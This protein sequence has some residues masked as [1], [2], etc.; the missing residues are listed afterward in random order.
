MTLSRRQFL[1]NAGAAAVAFGGLSSL[2]ALAQVYAVDPLRGTDR[3]GQL[4]RDPDGILNLP[5]GFS[6]RVISRTGDTMSDGLTTPSA[7]DGMAA[8]PAPGKPGYS[9]LVRNHE[10]DSIG[11]EIGPFHHAPARARAMRDRAFDLYQDKL[12]VNGGTTTLLYNHRSG[13]VEKSHLSLLGTTRNCAGGATPWGSWLTCEES[14]A[15]RAEGFGRDHGF[16][17]E[18]PANAEGLVTPEPLT[19]MGR[20]VHEAAAVD[21]S[22]GIVYLTED[23]DNALFYRFLPAQSEQLRHGGQLQ[24][25]AIKGWPGALTRNWEEDKNKAE[26]SAVSV[27]QKFQCTW[28]DL[29]DVASPDGDLSLRG[30][31]AGAARFCRCEGV[32]FALR[33]DGR[34][35]IYFAATGGGPQK[36]GQIWCYRP[37]RHEGAGHEIAGE[38]ELVYESR[39]RA[40]LESCDNLAIAPW[41]DLIICE[42]SYSSSPDMV[43]YIRGLTPEGKLYTLAMNAHPDKGEFCGA[44]FSPDGSTLFVNIQRP[45]MTLAINGPWSR[46]RA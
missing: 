5:Q 35:E 32:A 31:A 46:L 12:P 42:D 8:F 19:A 11:P 44:C 30:A 41:G 1:I 34:R 25:L 38:L 27:G 28:I 7:P 39:D 40:L 18:V 43:N 36:I 33:A 23:Y 14:L 4:F 22:S 9:L 45:G 24:A 26:A 20:F 15:G 3:F 17:F 2:P 16:V 10:L 29:E 37:G 13:T 21:S 6:Y